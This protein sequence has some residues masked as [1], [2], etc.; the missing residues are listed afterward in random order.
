[1]IIKCHF[2]LPHENWHVTTA[3]KCMYFSYN[4]SDLFPTDSFNSVISV[5]LLLL[6]ALIQLHF[7]RKPLDMVNEA[8]TNIC[9]ITSNNHLQARI[10]FINIW[11]RCDT[12]CMSMF[13]VQRWWPPLN[14]VWLYVHFYFNF[15]MISCSIENLR[16]SIKAHGVVFLQL[17]MYLQKKT[18]I[19]KLS[20]VSVNS[21]P[22]WEKLL[23]AHCP[24]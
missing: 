18:N 17:K 10:H 16:C 22:Q 21:F 1:M 14:T 20:C 13:T 8:Y 12:M 2:A 7:H 5:H 9:I 19:N 6:S 15:F 11:E 4:M 3:T 24:G 23:S